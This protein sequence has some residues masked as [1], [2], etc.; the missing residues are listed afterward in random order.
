MSKVNFQTVSR[1]TGETEI[2][3]LLTLQ[4]RVNKKIKT[5]MESK[6]GFS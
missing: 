4:K 3:H 5:E 6:T 1:G 2:M